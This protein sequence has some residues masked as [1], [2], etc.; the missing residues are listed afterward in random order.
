MVTLFFVCLSHKD[1]KG[2][3]IMIDISPLLTDCPFR[4]FCTLVKGEQADEQL[5]LFVS[6]NVP[7][8]NDERDNM[9]SGN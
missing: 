2:A 3:V 8:T 6:A 7:E 9:G 5:S 4:V 1:A